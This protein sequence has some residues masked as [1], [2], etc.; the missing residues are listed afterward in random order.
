M[1]N[2]QNMVEKPRGPGL[3][4]LSPLTAGGE[5][6]PLPVLDLSL[7][8]CTT[9]VACRGTSVLGVPNRD[10]HLW[11]GRHCLGLGPWEGSQG[12][13]PLPRKSCPGWEPQSAAAHCSGG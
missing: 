7:S 2:Y 5:E 9:C 11:G 4:E 8:P 10:L 6:V 3:R 13:R 1:H 12:T